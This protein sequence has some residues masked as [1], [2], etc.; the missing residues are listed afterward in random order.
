[1]TPFRNGQVTIPSRPPIKNVIAASWKAGTLP[2][3]AVSSAK[4]AHM[5]TAVKPMSVLPV[6][7]MKSG[8]SDVRLGQYTARHWRR[9]SRR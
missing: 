8:S 9:A 1:M 4:A 6:R 5:M 3:A 7:V 2:L